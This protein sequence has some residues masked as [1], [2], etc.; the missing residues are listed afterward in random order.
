MLLCRNNAATLSSS[1]S[2]HAAAT[3]GSMSPRVL[4]Q[5]GMQK[6]LNGDIPASIEYF[7]QADK[8][9]PDGSLRPYLWQR[10]ISYYYADRFEDGSRQFRDDVAVNPLDV[11]EIVWD[12]ACLSR[13]S[14]PDGSKNYTPPANMMS[15]PPGRT[16]RRKIMGTVYKLFR[17]ETSE[18]E[19]FRVGHQSNSKDEFYA[20]FYLGLFCESRGETSKAENYMRSAVKTNYAKGVGVSDY[21]TGC[22]RVHCQLRGWV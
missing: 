13:L 8:S 16:D 1:T 14:P 15:L 21:M 5:G 4:V 10:G 9:V 3:S 7:D 18:L 22:A 2:L 19:L 20:L 6:F 17:G 12:I 11:E